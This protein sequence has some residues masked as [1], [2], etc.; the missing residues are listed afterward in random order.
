MHGGLKD[1]RERWGA[2]WNPQ[3]WA[4]LKRSWSLDSQSASLGDL[5]TVTAQLEFQASPALP[6]TGCLG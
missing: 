1:R 4:G 2:G 5:T 3:S 6:P